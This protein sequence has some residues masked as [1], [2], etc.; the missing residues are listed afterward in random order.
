MQIVDETSRITNLI[1]KSQ[2]VVEFFPKMMDVN[3]NWNYF[4]ETCSWIMEYC[5]KIG[6][7]LVHTPRFFGTGAKSWLPD[8]AYL[9]GPLPVHGQ[10]TTF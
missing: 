5:L 1:L 6:S 3:I 4:I 8:D 7:I 2:Y 9:C 10:P